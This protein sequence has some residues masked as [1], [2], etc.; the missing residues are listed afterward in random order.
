[1]PFWLK[2]KR[3]KHDFFSRPGWLAIPTL[4]ARAGV[5]RP[6]RAPAGVTRALARSRLK[7]GV[8]A[9]RAAWQPP[10]AIGWPP[11]AAPAACGRGP[12]VRERPTRDVVAVPNDSTLKQAVAVPHCP[13]ASW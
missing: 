6:A 3:R 11:Q 2:P 10:L 7:P 9:A 5:N 1:M 13:A 4:T 8:V 12:G